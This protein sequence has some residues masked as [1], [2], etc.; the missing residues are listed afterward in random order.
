MFLPFIVKSVIIFTLLSRP[1]SVCAHKT[2]TK[3]CATGCLVGGVPNHTDSNVKV[4]PT[5]YEV[6]TL[7]WRTWF[8]KGA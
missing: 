8:Q 4:I 6:K 2:Q 7:D 1:L 3:V 5:I